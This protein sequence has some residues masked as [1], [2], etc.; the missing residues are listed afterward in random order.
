MLTHT[1]TKT[2]TTDRLTLRRFTPADAQSAWRNWAGDA[3]VQNDYNEPVY[4]TVEAAEKLL[5]GYI[6]AYEKPETYRWGVCLKDQPEN[7]TGQI[8]F[9]LVDSKNEFCEIEYCIG[10]AYQNKGYITEAVRAVTA[11]GFETVG[12]NRIQVCCRRV[13]LPSKRVIEKCGFTYEGTLRQYFNHFGE[14]QDRL[15]YAMLK[16]EYRK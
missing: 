11:F 4:K 7:C 2:I 13:N 14:F 6:E 9:Y 3:R 5:A 1:G 10:R 12:F 16:E 8:A 15:Y